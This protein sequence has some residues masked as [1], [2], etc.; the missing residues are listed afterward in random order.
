M[1]KLVWDGTWT[2]T[3]GCN[4]CGKVVV[5]KNVIEED[6]TLPKG[7]V[8]LIEPLATNNY[9]ERGLLCPNCVREVVTKKDRDI[10]TNEKREYK[11]E[12]LGVTITYNY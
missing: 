7:W 5:K 12:G 3:F 1:E 6:P 8:K 4:S 2:R 10:K 11:K 9:Y